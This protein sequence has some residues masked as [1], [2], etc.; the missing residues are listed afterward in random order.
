M[1]WLI[2]IHNRKVIRPRSAYH[3]KITVLINSHSATHGKIRTARIN[4]TTP[5]IT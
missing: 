3:I 2:G 5:K 4:M 1:G